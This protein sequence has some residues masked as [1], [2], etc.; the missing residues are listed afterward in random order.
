MAVEIFSI[1]LLSVLYLVYSIHGKL[2]FSM[3]SEDYRTDLSKHVSIYTQI[4][5]NGLFKC[6]KYAILQL[7]LKVRQK[8]YFLLLLSN[9]EDSKQLD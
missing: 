3:R 4:V 2:L 1:Q 5:R 7:T 8:C 9:Q 6:S